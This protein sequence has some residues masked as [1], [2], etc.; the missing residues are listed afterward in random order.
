M[1]AKEEVCTKWA[2]RVWEIIDLPFTC[3]KCSNMFK[4]LSRTD[5]Q[6]NV[7]ATLK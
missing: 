3:A 2:Q 1:P 4:I 5:L 6:P 7:P